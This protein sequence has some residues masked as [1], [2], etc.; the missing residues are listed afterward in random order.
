MAL[1]R[2]LLPLPAALA[3]AFGCPSSL[4]P[5]VACHLL[6]LPFQPIAFDCLPPFAS[7]LQ[8]NVFACLP[9]FAAALPQCITRQLSIVLRLYVLTLWPNAYTLLDPCRHHSW[10]GALA[11]VLQA[12]YVLLQVYCCLRGLSAPPTLLKASLPFCLP[13]NPTP[14]RGPKAFTCHSV[15][16]IVNTS[17]HTTIGWFHS[18]V[19]T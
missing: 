15:V 18:L 11:D 10:S 3:S 1:S 12:K 17:L 4:L 8:P 13:L 16:L 7:T 5:L 14:S 19:A 2:Y 6:L 9:P